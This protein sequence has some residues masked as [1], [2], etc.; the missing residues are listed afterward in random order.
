MPVTSLMCCGYIFGIFD[1]LARLATRGLD[2]QVWWISL[3][4]ERVL[5][6]NCALKLND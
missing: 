3:W 6:Q 4:Y 5:G 1:D 2:E